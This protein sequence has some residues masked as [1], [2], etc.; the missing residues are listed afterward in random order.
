MGRVILII[1]MG[2]IIVGL[3]AGAICAIKLA[4]DAEEQP[5]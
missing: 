4:A 3:G 5:W 1:V 2:I